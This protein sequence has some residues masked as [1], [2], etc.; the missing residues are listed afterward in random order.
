M[1]KFR[2]WE[3]CRAQAR[4]YKQRGRIF[5]LEEQLINYLSRV[6]TP[7]T[8]RRIQNFVHQGVDIEGYPFLVYAI[9][10]NCTKKIIELLL[11]YGANMYMEDFYSNG[12]NAIMMAI[13]AQRLDIIIL[14]LKN[15]LDPNHVMWRGMTP[16]HAA[17]LC[18]QHD[19]VQYLLA[20]GAF[21]DVRDVTGNTALHFAVKGSRLTIVNLLLTIGFNPNTKNSFCETPIF[22]VRNLDVMESL[23]RWGAM[24]NVCNRNGD[25]P[26]H[27]LVKYRSPMIIKMLI[28]H[29]ANPLITNKQNRSAIDIARFHER[30][31]IDFP[32]SNLLIQY[33]HVVKKQYETLTN[34]ILEKNKQEQNIKNII[35]DFI[36]D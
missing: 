30:K 9:L 20:S 32:I 23:L 29:Q 36:F 14:F 3:T 7:C 1:P 25:T 24:T 35:M 31:S 2:C 6:D 11:D 28:D 10:G 22:M 12:T 33:S 5:T 8:K 17:A 16:L 4:E 15:G 18:G 13:R 21:K 26:L 19:I 34:Q 27:R